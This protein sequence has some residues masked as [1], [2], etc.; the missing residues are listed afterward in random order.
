M[1]LRTS[2]GALC[3]AALTSA[4][5]AIPQNSPLEHLS[6]IQPILE[7]RTNVLPPAQM[8]MH[9]G[10]GVD[11]PGPG[12]M[13]AGYHRPMLGPGGFGGGGC[14]GGGAGGGGFMMADNLTSQIGF[15]GPDGMR[16]RWDVGGQSLFDSEPLGVP[17]RFNFPQGAIFRLKLTDIPGYPGVE[18]YPKLE[19]APAVPPTRAFIAAHY[20]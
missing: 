9:P 5:C 4:G 20:N 11:G 14:A 8:L 1:I 17:G 7:P 3:L 19:G 13:L 10:P 15:V 2:L 18:L 6:K 12:V 16:V